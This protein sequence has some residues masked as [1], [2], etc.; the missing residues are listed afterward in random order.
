LLVS[1]L[2]I[3]CEEVSATEYL[4]TVTYVNGWLPTDK[5]AKLTG[6][7]VENNREFVATFGYNITWLNYG[8]GITTKS[9][10]WY[11]DTYLAPA[12]RNATENDIFVLTSAS[13]PMFLYEL[14]VKK[15][16]FKGHTAFVETLNYGLPWPIVWLID[17]AAKFAGED[18]KTDTEFIHDLDPDSPMMIQVTQNMTGYKPDI[19]VLGWYWWIFD[20][21]NIG[22][23][24]F[25]GVGSM[26]RP[27]P[28][29]E[30]LV[31]NLDHVS[32]LQN[33]TVIEDMFTALNISKVNPSSQF[34]MLNARGEPA[35]V[36]S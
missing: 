5:L 11:A 17:T 9:A 20:W 21:F 13:G 2:T 10:I 23:F 33:E 8:N 1:F 27:F 31:Y 29:P 4:G 24:D 19:Q 15:V 35:G 14:L 3:T 34:L 16:P 22:A 36:F 12:M 28:E 32:F 25:W 26:F 6:D 7:T 18:I 30:P